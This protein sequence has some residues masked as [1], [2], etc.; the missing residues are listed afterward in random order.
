MKKL[1]WIFALLVLF[2]IGDRIGGYLLK[3]LCSKSQFR[4]SRLYDDRAESDILL[5]GNSR[6]LIFYQPYIEQITEKRSFNLSYNGMPVDLAAQLVKDYY[7]RYA[8]PDLLLIEVSMCDRLNNQL[9]SGFSSYAPYSK[10]LQQ[11]IADSLPT[12]AGAAR[13]SHLYR[14]NSEVFLR[15]LYY[16]QS[17]D[18]HWLTD[19]QMNQPLIAGASKAD[20]LNFVV[21][22][23]NFVL[24]KE[25]IEL[26]E[27]KGTKVELVVSPY[28]PPFAKRFKNFAQ[29]IARLEQI[30]GKKIRLYTQAVTTSDAFSDYQHLNKKGARQ[31]L[32]LLKR[33]GV[34]GGRGF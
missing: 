23:R 7:N 21:L 6:G 20:S 18:K 17:D 28:Y 2:F 1:L 24:L 32:D 3:Q 5:L 26:A 33:D 27:S 4:Y 16:L 29:W 31:Y 10:G 11:L 34:L 12:N 13:L 30:T 9:S 25:L 22:E 8:A 15:S 19:R 14:Y